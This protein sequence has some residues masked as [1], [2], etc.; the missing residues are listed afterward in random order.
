MSFLAKPLF[1]LLLAIVLVF[2]IFISRIGF[3]KFWRLAR[4]YIITSVI[5][6]IILSFIFLSG[7]IIGRIFSGFLLSFRFMLLISSGI[8][9]ASITNPIEI[10]MG[11]MQARFPHKYG[12]TLMISLRMMA[13]LTVKIQKVID[14][15]KARGASF[16]FSFKNALNLMNRL[17]ALFVP[18]LHFTLETAIQLSDTLISRGYNPRGKITY[19]PFKLSILDYLFFM[20]SLFIIIITIFAY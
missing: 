9:F 5:G 4:L 18:I 19:R 7:E 3:G 17:A 6:I 11:F 1:L 16:R 10:P 14:A 13:L 15:Q 12:V 20:G 8:F 2:A